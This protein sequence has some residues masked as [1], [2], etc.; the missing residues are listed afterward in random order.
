MHYNDINVT[1]ISH[2]FTGI[3]KSLNSVWDG[4]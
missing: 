4:F 1:T 3:D 2:Y